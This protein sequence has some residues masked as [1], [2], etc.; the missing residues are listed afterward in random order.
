MKKSDIIFVSIVLII[1]TAHCFAQDCKLVTSKGDTINIKIKNYDYSEIE[2][3]RGIFPWRKVRKL[4]FTNPITISEKRLDELN[5]YTQIQLPEKPHINT[6]TSDVP[7]DTEGKLHYIQIDT[8]NE[9]NKKDIYLASMQFITNQFK[10]A[11]NVIQF[12]DE[13]SG[14]II[15]KGWTSFSFGFIEKMWF[16]FKIQAKDGRYRMEFYDVYWE[17]RNLNYSTFEV[18]PESWFGVDKYYDSRGY[19][20]DK[21]VKNKNQMIETFNRFRNQLM[22]DI[23]SASKNGKW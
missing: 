8:V 5:R 2:T 16:T 17:G 20:K 14:I 7:T 4:I 19:P 1:S 13:E 9:L 6:F 10:S 21:F 22:A 11:N 18:F 3:N 15:V 23:K 12:K